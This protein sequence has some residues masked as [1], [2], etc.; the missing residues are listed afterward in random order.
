LGYKLQEASGGEAELIVE[1]VNQ[2]EL[3][4]DPES[5]PMGVEE[6]QELIDGFFDQRALLFLD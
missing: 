6:A 2:H 4:I 5:T 1:I 3:T